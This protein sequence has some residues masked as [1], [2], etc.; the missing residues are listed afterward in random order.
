ML[1][2]FSNF[3]FSCNSIV[4][5]CDLLISKNG[6]TEKLASGLL[7]PFLAHLK[8]AQDQVAKGGYSII[9]KPKLDK[10]VSWFTKGTVE[11]F[12]SLSL[13]S[14]FSNME[15]GLPVK[16]C[17]HRA[18]CFNANSNAIRVTSVPQLSILVDYKSMTRTFCVYRFVRFVSTPEVL[19]RVYT[20]ESEIL[21]IE[22]AIVIQGSTEAA[23]NAVSFIYRIKVK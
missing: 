16:I 20:L 1:W 2:L 21:Q 19:E 17:T 15:C 10:D 4:F 22:E 5:R 8:T 12:V 3:T 11:R 6:K 14:P 13:F 18:V 7:N 9:L 23:Q